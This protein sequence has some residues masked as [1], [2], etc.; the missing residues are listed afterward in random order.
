VIPTPT[1]S[2]CGHLGDPKVLV[3][4]ESIPLTE[5]VVGTHAA[6]RFAPCVARTRSL[7][8][9]RQAEPVERSDFNLD[10]TKERWSEWTAFGAVGQRSFSER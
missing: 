9:T 8:P 2:S 4:G 1:R 5:A 7:A 10:L 6:R 3:R